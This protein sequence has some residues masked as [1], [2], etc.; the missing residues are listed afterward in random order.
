MSQNRRTYTATYEKS[1]YRNNKQAG[2]TYMY[3]SAAPKRVPQE[4][5]GSP[6]RK[7]AQ[8]VPAQ[9]PDRRRSVDVSLQ[10]PRRQA[11]VTRPYEVRK[12][13]EKALHMSAGYV[14]FLATALLAAAFILVNYIQLQAELTGLT[15]TVAAKESELNSLKQENDEAYN[16]IVNSIDLEEIR[17]IAIQE[18]GMIYAKEGQIVIYENE[19]Y[20]YMRQV[21]E[22]KQ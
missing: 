2:N 10:Q 4:F 18:L 20:D 9:Q 8:T 5:P 1:A 15:K 13:R 6:A 12:N 16:R 11:P 3:G 7:Q 22:D 14:L 17:R 21:T 19:G